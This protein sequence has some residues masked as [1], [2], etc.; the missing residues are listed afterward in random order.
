MLSDRLT[1]LH[2]QLKEHEMSKADMTICDARR[3]YKIDGKKEWKWVQVPVATLSEGEVVR[4]TH[5]HGKVRIHRQKVENGPQDHVE[6]PSRV[7]SENCCGGRNF[8]GTHSM[9]SR[10]VE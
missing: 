8:K 1:G 4:C 7:D 3:Q 6:H 9:S 5:C 2:L 10:P